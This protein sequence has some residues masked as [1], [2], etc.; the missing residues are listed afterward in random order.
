MEEHGPLAKPF[1]QKKALVSCSELGMMSRELENSFAKGDVN[2]RL[3]TGFCS[4]LALMM[5]DTS[6]FLQ[7]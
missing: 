5:C 7:S 1:P 3:A 6:T 4:K 2:R